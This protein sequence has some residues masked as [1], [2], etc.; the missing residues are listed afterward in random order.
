MTLPA[1]VGR[2]PRFSPAA[3][4]LFRRYRFLDGTFQTYFSPGQKPDVITGYYPPTDWRPTGGIL[5]P[6]QVVWLTVATIDAQIDEY[7]ETFTNGIYL[8]YTATKTVPDPSTWVNGT[9]VVVTYSWFFSDGHILTSRIESDIDAFGRNINVTA[10]P[11]PLSAYSYPLVASGF[12]ASTVDIAAQLVATGGNL[13]RNDKTDPPAKPQFTNSIQAGFYA[14]PLFPGCVAATDPGLL[15]WA[16]SF[17]DANQIVYDQGVPNLMEIQRERLLPIFEQF[18]TQLA[19]IRGGRTWAL[20]NDLSFWGP[21]YNFQP[22]LSHLIAP[23]STQGPFFGVDFLH[24]HCLAYST[25]GLI[26]Q[27]QA[28]GLNDVFYEPSKDQLVAAYPSF[29]RYKCKIYGPDGEYDLFPNPSA[30]PQVSAPPAGSFDAGSVTGPFTTPVVDNLML[31]TGNHPIAETFNDNRYV[32]IQSQNAMLQARNPTIISDLT[33]EA[34]DLSD[35]GIEYAGTQSDI[36][37]A[38]TLMKL[39]ADYFNFDP[40]TGANLGRT[41]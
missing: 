32:E 12:V 27:D 28:G 1:Y 2:Q 29:V 38:N 24:I 5:T 10:F 39:I 25:G 9:H 30:I 36:S 15:A 14:L 21:D 16:D 31:N 33:A 40:D 35:S 34:S 37:D 6:P 26:P 17:S 7:K 3:G 11:S 41:K 23:D 19:A 4:Q 8:D 18:A 13:I 22:C 20:V